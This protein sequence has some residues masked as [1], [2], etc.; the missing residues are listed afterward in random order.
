MAIC[1]VI[2][3]MCGV[4]FLVLWWWGHRVSLSPVCLRPLRGGGRVPTIPPPE[5]THVLRRVSSAGVM[6]TRCPGVELRNRTAKPT[7]TCRG[8]ANRS[9]PGGGGAGAQCQQQEEANETTAGYGLAWRKLPAEE[10]QR[11]P[12]A[13]RRTCTCGVLFTACVFR[14]RLHGLAT[15]SVRYEVGWFLPVGTGG[16][17]DLQHTLAPANIPNGTRPAN[18]SPRV[19]PV[20]QFS[21]N[22]PHQRITSL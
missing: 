10:P 21:S 5:K 8:R 4:L 6:I 16:R 13:M 11:H 12:S 15:P 2:A 14:A 3:S 19:G 18:A 20:M 9:R 7:R 17:R 22:L 1:A